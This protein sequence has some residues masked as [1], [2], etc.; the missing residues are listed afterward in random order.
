MPWTPPV[1]IDIRDFSPEFQYMFTKRL[2]AFVMDIL[3]RPDAREILDA[4]KQKLIAQGRWPIQPQ[5][6]K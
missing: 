1:K 6:Q 4:Q 3:V 5:D 2:E